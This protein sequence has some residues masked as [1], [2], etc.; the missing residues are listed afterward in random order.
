MARANNTK[1]T[2]EADDPSEYS[3]MHRFARCDLY[4]VGGTRGPLLGYFLIRSSHSKAS[5]P[6]SLSFSFEQ[7]HFW[8]S[9]TQSAIQHTK[10][11]IKLLH[12]LVKHCGTVGVL[13]IVLFLSP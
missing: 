9:N 6:H 4:E 10:S 5:F 12:H 2:V 11:I 13:L 7:S 3:L 8:F 1:L